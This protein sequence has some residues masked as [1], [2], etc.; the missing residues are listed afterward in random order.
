MSSTYAQ[1]NSIS[2]NWI[3]SA[4]GGAERKFSGGAAAV[5]DRQHDA[6]SAMNNTTWPF[7]M[8]M[9]HLQRSSTLRS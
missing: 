8:Y 2:L 1:I 6:S 4:A 7:D 5:C 9:D 3:R